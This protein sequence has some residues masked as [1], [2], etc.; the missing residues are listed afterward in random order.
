MI[1][2]LDHLSV[3]GFVE[4]YKTDLRN[5]LFLVP[6]KMTVS[7]EGPGSPNLEALVAES[8][9]PLFSVKIIYGPYPGKKFLGLLSKAIRDSRLEIPRLSGIEE[10]SYFFLLERFFEETGDRLRTTNYGGSRGGL[11]GKSEEFSL[12]PFGV[13]VSLSLPK[14]RSVVE[15][16]R[17]ARRIYENNEIKEF[18]SISS[19]KVIALRSISD[20]ERRLILVFFMNLIN[21]TFNF[22]EVEVESKVHPHADVLV[23]NASFFPKEVLSSG[24]EEPRIYEIARPLLLAPERDIRNL[25]YLNVMLLGINK[26][27]VEKNLRAWFSMNSRRQ[28]DISPGREYPEGEIYSINFSFESGELER[29]AEI[30]LV[31]KGAV[32]KLETSIPSPDIRLDAGDLSPYRKHTLSV[33]HTVSLLFLD[34]G[35]DL[36]LHREPSSAI[37]NRYRAFSLKE[38][39]PIDIELYLENHS[40]LYRFLGKPWVHKAQKEEEDHLAMRGLSIIVATMLGL[41][42]KMDEFSFRTKGSELCVGGRTYN[43]VLEYMNSKLSQAKKESQSLLQM[44]WHMTKEKIADPLLFWFLYFV[45]EKPDNLRNLI[46]PPQPGANALVS[47]KFY[48]NEVHRILEEKPEIFDKVLE[49]LRIVFSTI[50]SLLEE[51]GEEDPVARDLGFVGIQPRLNQMEFFFEPS[52]AVVIGNDMVVSGELRVEISANFA[53]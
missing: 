16:L 33:S 30:P 46:P 29:Y 44:F 48:W 28:A 24:L 36:Y 43:P 19:Y 12:L 39:D 53:R 49:Y 51:R 34:R 18:L 31:P 38:V 26:G 9:F 52:H 1:D 37:E 13:T 17:R 23:S 11:L 40:F 27:D 35:S 20:A 15:A 42:E 32:F 3:P 8:G 45:F 47:N 22:F 50:L 14:D 41:F 5:L 6:A 25:S 2:K 10:R 4:A 7:F 21:E